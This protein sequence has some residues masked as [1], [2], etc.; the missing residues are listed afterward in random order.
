[1]KNLINIV[2]GNITRLAIDTGQI[3]LTYYND[4]NKCKYEIMN[5]QRETLKQ[6]LC[7]VFDQGEVIE[8]SQKIADLYPG[9]IGISFKR[10]AIQTD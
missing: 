8:L 4:T 1:M 10:E 5:N 3:C 6:G 9:K 7:T 2:L